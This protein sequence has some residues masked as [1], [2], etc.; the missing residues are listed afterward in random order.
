MLQHPSSPKSLEERERYDKMLKEKHR[1]HKNDWYQYLIDKD[2][3][4]KH[5]G[6]EL[7]SDPVSIPII[8][9]GEETVDN[10]NEYDSGLI[11]QWL[12]IQELLS[13]PE[14]MKHTMIKENQ[15]LFLDQVEL[16]RKQLLERGLQ[17]YM[18]GTKII[19]EEEE[20][21]EQLFGE[22]KFNR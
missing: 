3:L 15:D 2:D 6:H 22:K 14:Q 1:N 5:A 18:N 20:D 13:N 19:K 17:D 10:L 11:Q 7:Y 8:N 12:T 16:V 9:Q 21:E 4:F